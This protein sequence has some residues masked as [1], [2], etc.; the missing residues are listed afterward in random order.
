MSGLD[1]AIDD[2][3]A[4]EA[5]SSLAW[6]AA[7]LDEVMSSFSAVLGSLTGSGGAIEDTQVT[8]AIGDVK[9]EVDALRAS[10][11]GTVAALLPDLHGFHAGVAEADALLDAVEAR[12]A[13][14]VEAAIAAIGGTGEALHAADSAVA[15]RVAS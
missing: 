4:A 6:R 1:F 2:A 9:V 8:A 14:L 13:M 3:E 11:A 7:F 10:L 5:A 12:L 15:A